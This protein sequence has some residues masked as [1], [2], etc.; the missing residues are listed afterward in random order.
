MPAYP[1]GRGDQLSDSVLGGDGV[2]EH[3][4]VQD[5]RRVFPVSTRVRGGHGL[6]HVEDVRRVGCRA[7]PPVRVTGAW[8]FRSERCGPQ[9]CRRRRASR[10]WWAH[11]GASIPRSGDAL[12]HSRRR[13]THQDQRAR[14]N[15]TAGGPSAPLPAGWVS[16]LDGPR[17]RRAGSHAGRCDGRRGGP[18]RRRYRRWRLCARPVR[19][20]RLGVL[21]V[22]DG[23]ASQFPSGAANSASMDAAMAWIGMRPVAMS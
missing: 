1:A 17:G 23:E 21:R 18:R 12:R 8:G 16:G 3:R 5:A 4:G 2:V 13:S 9:R 15:P 7:R 14:R 11:S 6:E 22:L 19:R 20:S 10:R